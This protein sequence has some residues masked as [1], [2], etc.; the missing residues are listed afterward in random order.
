VDVRGIDVVGR[1]GVSVIA[2][3]VVMDT[4]MWIVVVWVVWWIVVL[5]RCV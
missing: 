4:G 3:D 1:I 5:G 2:V